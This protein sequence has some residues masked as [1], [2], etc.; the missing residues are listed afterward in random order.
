MLASSP[1]TAVHNPLSNAKL[2]VGAAPIV[3]MRKGGRQGAIG[4]DGS[5]S[6][7]GQNMFET[8]KA[9]ANVHRVSHR[10]PEW[11]LAGDALDMAGMAAPRRWG[12]PSDDLTRA[13]AA[14]SPFSTCVHLFMAP[15]EQLTGQI[16]HSELGQS[17]DTVIIGGEV[18]F[19]DGR[20]TRIDEAAIHQEAQEILT[21]STRHAR[22]PAAVREMYPMFREPGAG[23]GRCGLAFTGS[24]DE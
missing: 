15:K 14:T 17:L 20:M 6:A 11:I 24:A 22:A 3:E 1:A 12:S 9:A 10:Y 18:V 5:S 8:I 7:D 21:A 19:A 16:V 4:T 23:G 13:Y 2:G